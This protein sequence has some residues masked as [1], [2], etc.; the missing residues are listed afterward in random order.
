MLAV[1][2]LIV[3]MIG[4]SAESRPIGT[5]TTE[6]VNPVMFGLFSGSPGTKRADQN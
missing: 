6:G 3:T 1:S 4:W 5:T 2:L